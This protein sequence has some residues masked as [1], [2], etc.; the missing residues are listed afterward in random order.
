MMHLQTTNPM[1]QKEIASNLDM[2]SDRAC[3]VNAT[4]STGKQNW[5]LASL[6]LKAGENSYTLF[7]SDTNAILSKREAS[8][9]IDDYLNGK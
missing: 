5:F 7:G 6:I 3:H 2:A 8:Q 9:Y 1:T 4:G